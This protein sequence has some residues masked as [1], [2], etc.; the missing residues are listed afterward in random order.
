MLVQAPVLRVCRKVDDKFVCLQRPAVV[1]LRCVAVETHALR[2]PFLAVPASHTVVTPSQTALLT[3]STK[4]S[5]EPCA[6]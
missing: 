1:L 6:P 4:R 2:F 5:S 3:F